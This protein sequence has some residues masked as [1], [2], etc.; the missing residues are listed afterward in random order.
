MDSMKFNAYWMLRSAFAASLLSTVCLS[1]AVAA[2]P[3][4]DVEAQAR[5]A[6]REAIV[7]T[8]VP[9]EGCFY[10]TYPNNSWLKVG[11]TTAPNRPFRPRTG[12]ISNT[13]GDGND[14]AAEVSGLMTRSIGSFPTVT[15]VTSETGLDG[16]NDYS[17]QLNSNF[18]TTAACHGISGCLSWQQFVYSSG[19]GIAFMQY[20]L[21]NYSNSKTDKCPAGWNHDYPNCYKNSAA[22]S[23]PLQVITELAHLQLS[24]S[25]VANGKDTLIFTTETEAYT[26]SGSD[27]IV[28]LATDWS[29]SEFNVFGD[30][31]GSAAVFNNGSTIKVRIGVFNGTTDIPTCAGPTDAG[32]TAETNNLNLGKCSALGGAKPMINFVEALGAK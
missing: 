26:T 3:V 11:C 7:E 23:V 5:E 15:G 28:D 32:T 14:Y 31:D 2:A 20:W 21:I 10:A 18:M 6:W 27:K 29:E 22:V 25:A 17:L 30:G 24:G 16:P 9:G 12:A 13:V 4:A 19:V 1:Y 8:E